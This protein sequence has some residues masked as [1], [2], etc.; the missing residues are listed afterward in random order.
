MNTPAPSPIRVV[1]LPLL[2]QAQ[3]RAEKFMRESIEG[4]RKALE[5]K[6]W[7]LEAYAP[8]P[9]SR[10]SRAD[11]QLALHKRGFAQSVTKRPEGY[12]CRRF[13]APDPV[14]WAPEKIQAQIQL[15]RKIAAGQYEN[16]IYKLEAKV[17]PHLTASL[18]GN[19]VW[20]ESYLTVTKEGGVKEVWHTKQIINF[21]K[22]GKLFNQWPTRKLKR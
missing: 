14:V 19:H 12:A 17:G 1:V 6:G 20:G 15:A 2:E 3:D 10:M 22:L 11:Y 16:F 4:V 5:E 21:S 13:G 8:Y 7:D 18:E 9:D